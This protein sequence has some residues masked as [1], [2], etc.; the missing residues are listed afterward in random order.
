MGRLRKFMTVATPLALTAVFVAACGS[1]GSGSA[2]AA[3]RTTLNVTLSSESD[4]FNPFTGTEI[5]K[6]QLFDATQT[7]LVG[8]NDEGQVIGRLAASW[9]ISPDA[10]TVTVKLKPKAKWSDGQSLTSADVAFTFARYLDTK[11]SS[12]ASRVGAVVGEDD[13]AAGKTTLPA[14]ITTPDAATVVF[15][16]AAPDGAWINQVASLDKFLPIL[17]QHSLHTVA[18]ADLQNSSFFKTWPVASGPYKLV[19]WKSG[20]YAHLV[21]NTNWWAGT[22]GFKDVYMRVLDSQAALAQLRSGDLQFDSPVAARDEASIHGLGGGFKIDSVAGVAPVY[23]Q[24]NDA[25]PLLADP[26]VKQAIV[27]AIDRQGI[28]KTILQGECTVPADNLRQLGPKWVLSRNSGLIQ[29]NHDVNK[30]K[31]L[32][33]QAGWKPNTTLTLLNRPGE[34]DIDN[35]VNII[36]ANLQAVGIKVQVQNTDTAGLLRMAQT[37]TGYQ[38]FTISGG[39]F[40]T[41]PDNLAAYDECAT[42]Y[43]AG[44]NTGQYCVPGLD[45]QWA[46]GLAKSSQADRTAIYAKIYKTLN[47]NPE[48]VTLYNPNSLAAQDTHLT[49]VKIHGNPSSVYWNI[50]EWKWTQ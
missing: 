7:P 36:Q 37:H 28:C 6:G 2:G 46:A 20:Q 29:Y 43:P 32:L 18:L 50:G 47:A 17:P 45:D 35:A 40:N 5:G 21:A 12:N 33:A 44:S 27:Y 14:G 24:F 38:M 15:A 41:D 30:A 19:E 31:Q 8:T 3:P 22:P 9:T 4:D 23:L 42:R 25:D 10:R 49:G 48:G 26:R 16:L 34:S 1:G 13:F 11:I 39:T